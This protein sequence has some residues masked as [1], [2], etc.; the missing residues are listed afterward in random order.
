MPISLVVK[1]G[2]DFLISKQ[3]EDGGWGESYKSCDTETYIHHENSQVVNTAYA[4]LALMAGKY[5]NEEPIRRGIQLIISRQLPTGEW[6][7]ES[8]EGI[9][10]KNAAV[11]YP[12]Y[13]FIFTIWALG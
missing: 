8:I 10:S 1:K 13:K 6:K 2:C 9:F 11:C 7:P 5:P 12:S 4:L 3:K